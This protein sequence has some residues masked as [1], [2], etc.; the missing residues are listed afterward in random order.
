M[1]LWRRSPVV[2]VSPGRVLQGLAQRSVRLGEGLRAPRWKGPQPSAEGPRRQRRG[3]A[4]PE[5][6]VP[7]RGLALP[8]ARLPV[9]KAAEAGRGNRSCQLEKPIWQGSAGP[10]ES[11]RRG[12]ARLMGARCPLR[13]TK[14]STRRPVCPEARLQ[15]LRP[16]G[17]ARGRTGPATKAPSGRGDSRRSQSH[18]PLGRV[19]P[20]VLRFPQ[21]PGQQVKMGLCSRPAGSAGIPGLGQRRPESILERQGERQTAAAAEETP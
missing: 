4:W 16:R 18:R 14:R 20:T 9:R 17:S 19:D 12:R 11:R 8:W 15:R 21:G 3:R 5:Q 1:K 2:V 10:E 7:H 6:P 13:C